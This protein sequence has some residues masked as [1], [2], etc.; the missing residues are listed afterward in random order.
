MFGSN[1]AILILEPATEN[2][3]YFIDS[4]ATRTDNYIGNAANSANPGEE[5]EV[6][7]GLPMINHPM[8]YSRGDVFYLGPYK[9]QAIDEHRVLMIIEETIFP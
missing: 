5:V 7:I 4:N 2:N 1:F 9:Y 8:S 6:F 3:V